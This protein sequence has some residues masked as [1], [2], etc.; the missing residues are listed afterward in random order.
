MKNV[1]DFQIA[2]VMCVHNLSFADDAGAADRQTKLRELYRG[3]RPIGGGKVSPRV[4]FFNR[5]KGG[6]EEEDG[7]EE[8]SDKREDS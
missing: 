2:A 8:R 4:S 1:F 6:E 5:L 3:R 7:G